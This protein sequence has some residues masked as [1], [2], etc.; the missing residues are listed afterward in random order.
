MNSYK[1]QIIGIGAVL[2]LA[3]A[4]A[5]ATGIDN[6]TKG[7][8]QR[9]DTD[10]MT[11]SAKQL[12]DATPLAD[13][14]FLDAVCCQLR[15]DDST[16]LQL[17][18]SCRTVNPNA[19]EAYYRLAQ[20]YFDTGNDS[21]ATKYM[22]RAARLQ[23][24]N[25]TYQESVAATY[26]QQRDYDNAIKAYENLYSHYR[27]RTDILDILVRLYGAKKDYS[28]MLSTID[29]MEKVDG[30]SD[31]LTLL[32]MNVYEMRHDTKNAYRMLKALNDAHPNEP[33]YK[34]MLGNWLMNHSRRDEAFKYLQ[35]ALADDPQNAFALNSM[36]DYYR[37]GG[38]NAAADEL[39]EKILFSSQTEPKTKVTMLQQAIK[40]SEQNGGDSVTVLNLFDRTMKASPKDADISNM[41]AMYMKLKGMPDDSVNAA[42][43]HTLSI[44]PDN[45]MA[46]VKLIQDKWDKKKWDEVISLSTAGTQYNPDDMVFYYFL[47]LGY[48]QKDDDDRALDALKRGVGEIND[49]TDP[50]IASDFYGSMGDILFKKKRQEE[51]FE[52]Y[53]NSLKWKE[54]NI[55]VLNNYAYY[56]SEQRR[57]LKRAEQMSFKTVQAEPTN[58]TYLDTYAWILFLQKRYDEARAYID[59]AL[60]NDNDST[61]GPSA[62]VIGHAGDIYC[63]CGDTDRAV[64]LWQRALKAGGDKA[65]LTRKIKTKKL[66]IE[67]Q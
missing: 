32:K 49:R 5:I 8:A 1:N 65:V 66:K 46:R 4:P 14:L 57:D 63:M 18:D 39:R 44:E 17:L 9:P 31:E 21:I 52:A 10:T 58:S 62:V 3:I 36:Y 43:E 28:R 56:L 23:P 41:K 22:E 67:E 48:F 38:D 55:V 26:I 42:F 24:A 51:A 13:R 35:G 59:R 61:N 64:E 50:D 37:S 29:R 60:E 34:V 40:E 12:L 16:A 15:G 53:D 6:R 20:Q 19:A 45:N 33:N 7:S 54:D 30:E 47:G 27:E 25:D 11:I 2:L